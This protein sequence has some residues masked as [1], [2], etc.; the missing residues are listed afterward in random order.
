MSDA[1]VF[2]QIDPVIFSFWI[3]DVRWYG[4]MYLVGLAFA[5]WFG[6]REARAGRSPFTEQQVGDL[7]FYGFMG[8]VIGGRIG[9][10]FFYQF[11]RFLADP[12]YL[13]MMNQGGM[14]FHGGLLGVLAVLFI[15][16]RITKL[17]FLQIGD[18]VA[19]L[20][21]IGLAAGRF[22]NFLNG[23]L[24]GRTTDVPWG[25]IFPN[26]G[27]LPRHPSQ[28]YEFFLEGLVL[29]GI[30]YWFSRK[31]RAV[32]AAS[33]IFLLGYGSFRFI[34]EFFRQP[35][36]HLG[37]LSFGMSM[38]QWLSLPMALGGLGLLIWATKNQPKAING[39]LA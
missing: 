39:K 28:L 27:P 23:E 15:Y 5:Y 31:P 8:A 30:L 26:A 9:Y 11:E 21:P 34:I 12:I 18:C 1:I 36:D 33:G 6:T 17:T 22:G 13:F 10:V 14:S 32:G 35:D 37:L 20:V 24:W 38:G 4:L 19:P 25:I 16:S 7:L 29:F 3:F 2:P